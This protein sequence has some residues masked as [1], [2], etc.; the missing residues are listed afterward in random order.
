MASGYQIRQHSSRLHWYYVWTILFI[1]WSWNPTRPAHPAEQGLFLCMSYDILPRF[2]AH[3]HAIHGNVLISA[4]PDLLWR[5]NSLS[6]HLHIFI[7]FRS[8]LSDSCI[9]YNMQMTSKEVKEDYMQEDKVTSKFF[10]L[11]AV[12]DFIPSNIQGSHC[13]RYPL[14]LLFL[15]FANRSYI[16]PSFP[17]LKTH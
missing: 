9:A 1:L 4:H 10:L 13:V 15:F 2:R 6:Q 12:S 7:L 17:L 11:T 3:I 14:S 5:E 16:P 8:G